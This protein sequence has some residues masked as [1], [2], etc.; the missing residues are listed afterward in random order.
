MTDEMKQ[1]FTRRIT[2][3]NRTE[4]VVITYEIALEYLKEAVL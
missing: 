4:M 3:A 1:D 2:A